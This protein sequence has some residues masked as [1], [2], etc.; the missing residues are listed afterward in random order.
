MV[1]RIVEQN[2]LA[3]GKTKQQGQ[4]WEGCD[5]PIGVWENLPSI[6]RVHHCHPVA[7][8]LV[9]R[10]NLIGPQTQVGVNSGMV[11]ADS[12]G[13]VTHQVADVER[14]EM[15]LADTPQAGEHGVNQSLDGQALKVIGYDPIRVPA[16][17]GWTPLCCHSS[18]AQL[19]AEGKQPGWL[20][21]PRQSGSVERSRQ[22]SQ[23]RR[24]YT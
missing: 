9:R 15:S 14:R 17:Q 16:Q 19:G 2:R 3:I 22:L 18:L 6:T 23:E 12:F 11:L 24:L 10:H 8:N 1:P 20:W 5:Q 21:A 7:M 4:T 13:V